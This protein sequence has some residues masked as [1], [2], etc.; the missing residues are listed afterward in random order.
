MEKEQAVKR[1]IRAISSAGKEISEEKELD[2]ELYNLT[3]TPFWTKKIVSKSLIQDYLDQMEIH[4]L[5]HA[6][7]W[8][9]AGFERNARQ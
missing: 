1:W 3:G 8:N 9:F 6:Q 4:S 5:K 7:T 2:M